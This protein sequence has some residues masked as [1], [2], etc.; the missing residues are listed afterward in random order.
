MACTPA[1]RLQARRRRHTTARGFN[2]RTRDFER[3]RG[4]PHGADGGNFDADPEKSFAGLVP[5]YH[6]WPAPRPASF[7]ERHRREVLARRAAPL[8][9]RRLDAC[10]GEEV[11]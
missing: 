6:T 9:H 7:F 4:G 1:G 5:S 8:A 11:E 3:M 2:P 10:A